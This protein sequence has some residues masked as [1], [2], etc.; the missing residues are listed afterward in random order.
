MKKNECVVII[1]AYEPSAN[2]IEYSKTL[3]NAHIAH[4]IVVNDGSGEK[5]QP[6]FDELKTLP[7]TTV[8]SYGENHGKGYALKIAFKFAKENFDERFTFVTADCDGQHLV[9]DVFN[10]FSYASEFGDSFVLGVRDFSQDHVP[11]RSRVGNVFTRRAYKFLY[12]VRIS[13]TQTGLR[14]FPYALLDSLLDIKGDRFEYE[15]NQLIVLHKKDIPIREV[16]IATVYEEKPD[17]VEKVS[18]YHAFKDSMRVGKVLLTNLSFFVLASV[19]STVIELLLL[20]FG[21]EYLPEL[22]VLNLPRAIVAQFIARLCSSIVNFFV[23]YKFVFNGHSKKSVFRYYV[24]WAFLFAASIGYAQLFDYWFD[25]EFLIT[26]LTGCSSL[27][28]SL[29]SY[30]VQTRWVFAGGKR[31]DGKFWGW[32]SRFIRWCYKTFTKRYTSL[33]AKDPVGAVYVCRHLNMHGPLTTVSKIGFDLHMM[34]FAPF[35]TRKA[36]FRQFRDYTF[37]VVHNMNKFWSTIC[38]FFMTIVLVPLIK[39]F[40]G[41]PVHRKDTQAI[42]TLKKALSYLEIHE[43]VILYPD[44]EYT[45]DGETDTDIYTGFL[46]LEKFY[47]KKFQKHLRFIPLVIDDENNTIVEKPPIRFK[48]GDFKSQMDDVKQ[49]LMVALGCVHNE[50]E[51]EN[52]TE[53]ETDED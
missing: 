13:D 44:I 3:I 49:K 1:P 52:I 40:E 5:Y 47:Y 23:N 30:Q 38:A 39:S 4:L 9:D 32:Y 21:L 42:F 35:C 45:A 11:K 36:C 15:M 29:L 22:M 19:F 31:K 8:L 48:N 50:N 41:I 33:V 34:V 28:M 7:N 24:L 53:S 17:D 16:P 25:N 20:Y 12:G 43:N 14:A 27:V 10:V 6:I 46:L 26:F 37:R 51:K 2:F 18:H